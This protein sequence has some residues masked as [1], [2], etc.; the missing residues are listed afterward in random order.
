MTSC[1]FF[2]CSFAQSE[3]ASV[4]LALLCRGAA[5]FRMGALSAVYHGKWMLQ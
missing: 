5:E 1:Y 2:L 3:A 4:I